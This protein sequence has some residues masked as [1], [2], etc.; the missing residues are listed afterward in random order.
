MK[1]ITLASWCLL[2]LYAAILLWLL[3]FARS[4]TSD[5]RMASG[6]L[7]MLLVP[8]FILAGINL[9]PYHFTRVAVLVLSVAPAVLAVAM[10][11]ASPIVSKVRTTLW[12]REDAA[13][14]DGSYYFKDAAR[15]KLV[16]DIN[17]L[18]AEK[19][20][21]DMQQPVPDLNK[22]GREQ[23]TLFDFAANMG[24]EADS[25]KLIACF[26]VLLKNGAK[27]DNGDRAHTP[28][29]LRVLGYDPV[30]LKWFLENGADPNAREAGSGAPI[31]YLAVGGENSEPAR[32]LKIERVRMLL[33]HGADPN[34]NVPTPDSL[35]I[36]T[37]IL[38]SAANIEAWTIC[39]MLLDRGA[40]ISY[41]TPGGSNVTKTVGYKLNDYRAW[42][43]APP[44]DL[45]ALA[46]RL[47]VP[48][49]SDK[50]Q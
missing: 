36:P 49:A 10:L 6:Y 11:I 9:L 31:L 15:Q 4:G 29:H 35:T 38:L 13:Q 46:K 7:M 12:A 17:A 3:L 22:T 43:T 30:Y 42:G 21:A 44:E 33:E 20:H 18:D 50:P 40:D 23:T 32:P 14:A 28:T 48:V 2:G 19:L 37:S 24:L 41:E 27:I 1:T 5:D 34:A 39:N 47:N 16:A 25:A 8:I 45:I 26:A